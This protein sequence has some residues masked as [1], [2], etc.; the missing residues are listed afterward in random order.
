MQKNTSAPIDIW[1]NQTQRPS[2]PQADEPFILPTTLRKQVGVTGAR[3][4]D[5]VDTQGRGTGS[6]G[7]DLSTVRDVFEPISTKYMFK[8]SVSKWS[9]AVE[10]LPAK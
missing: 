1:I 6:S 4:S 10:A 7:P 9:R 3:T 5:Q 2:I 8:A